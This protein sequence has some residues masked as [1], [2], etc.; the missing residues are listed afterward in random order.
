[1][2]AFAGDV[3]LGRR[4]HEPNPGEQRHIREAHRLA[5]REALLDPIRP[6]L[7]R[8]EHVSLN[9]E[10]PVF[11]SDPRSLFAGPSLVD[12]ESGSMINGYIGSLPCST[13]N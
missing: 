12:S 4:Y 1:M 10:T 11:D 3:M 8:A 6:Y 9:L 13:M 7:A 2:L 5:D